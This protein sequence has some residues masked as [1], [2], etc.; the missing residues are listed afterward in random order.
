M[1]LA[2]V[3]YRS[4]RVIIS[5]AARRRYFKALRPGAASALRRIRR[6]VPRCQNWLQALF[7]GGPA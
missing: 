5:V 6:C 1:A 4:H 2:C 7:D 3:A